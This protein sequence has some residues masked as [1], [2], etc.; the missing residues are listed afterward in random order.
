MRPW[1]L[2]F[3]LCILPFSAAVADEIPFT[4][5]TGVTIL[6]FNEFGELQES[7]ETPFWQQ[8]KDETTLR[9]ERPRVTLYQWDSQ[10]GWTF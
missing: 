10:G 3:M 6:H 5:M 4:Y 9:I 8:D 2:R 7:L 1:L